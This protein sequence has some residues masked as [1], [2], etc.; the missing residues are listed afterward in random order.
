[1]HCKSYHHY[2]AKLFIDA[3]SSL[4]EWAIVDHGT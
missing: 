1:M 2:F 4:L 3:K